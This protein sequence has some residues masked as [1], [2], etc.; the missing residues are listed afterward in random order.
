MMSTSGSS[1]F[2]A[3]ILFV[4]EHGDVWETYG[5]PLDCVIGRRIVDDDDRA[6]A[7]VLHRASFRS[8]RVSSG[9]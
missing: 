3:G 1:R 6:S 9:D 2:E 4:A 7:A 8:R 5:R